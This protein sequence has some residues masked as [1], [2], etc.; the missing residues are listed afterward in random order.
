M[1]EDT[2]TSWTPTAFIPKNAS[3]FSIGLVAI[4]LLIVFSLRKHYADTGKDFY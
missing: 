1:I 3:G 4:I 2:G